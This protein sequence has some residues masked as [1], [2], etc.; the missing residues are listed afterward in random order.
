[1]RNWTG[2]DLISFYQVLHDTYGHQH[3]W[4]SDSAF[5]TIIGAIL[6]QNVSW[7]GAFQAV[8]ALSEAHLL[9]PH[10]L[11]NAGPS[12]I[13]PLIRS[14]RYYNQKANKIMNFLEWFLSSC[15]GEIAKMMAIPTERA[16]DELL[17][18]SGF[19]P[20]TVDSILLYA[21]EKP[22]F[23]VDAYTRRIGSRQGWFKQTAT[24]AQMQEYFMDRLSP[25]V[26]LYNDF[27]AQIV[28]LGNK[29]C[30]KNPLCD[31]CP[32]RIGSGLPGCIHGKNQQTIQSPEII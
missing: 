19:G 26:A 2:T 30:K 10:S 32:V 29:V 16:R 24:Y 25:D 9:D 27:H 31:T 17:T 14:S 8:C 11:Y 7:N 18:I 20:E 13:A 12:L 15:K 3:W 5:E 21:L 28:N 22:I 4:P 6:A 23:V 1:M